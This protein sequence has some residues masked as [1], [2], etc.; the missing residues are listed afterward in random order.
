M[1]LVGDPIGYTR[2]IRAMKATLELDH[3]IPGHG[4]LSPAEP[5]VSWMLAYLEELATS[6]DH[7][8]RQGMRIEEMMDEIPLRDPLTL[9]PDVPGADRFPRLM[10]SLHRLNVLL[11]YRY[12]D[13]VAPIR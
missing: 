11:A 12:F 6:V 8:R 2:S 4:P 5:S 9:P 13:A 3:F 1:L 10:Q 7:R